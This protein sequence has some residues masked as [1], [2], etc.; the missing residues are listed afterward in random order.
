[1]GLVELTPGANM[2]YLTL[3]GSQWGRRAGLATVAG[4]TC[5]LTLYMLLAVAG[6]GEVVLR[7]S[8]LYT[9][10]RWAGVGYLVWLAV[11][12]WRGGSGTSPGNA[13]LPPQPGRLFARGLIAN[14]L[15]PKAVVFYVALLPG[16]TNPSRG[17]LAIQA[18]SLGVIHVTLSVAVHTT[19]V[20]AA[21]G[22][23]RAVGGSLR[24][25]SRPWIDRA[26]ALGLAA[27]AVWLAWE[28]FRSP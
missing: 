21:G 18:L 7:L 28:T 3:V 4:I 22:A 8:L 20:L 14:L 11:R 2:A 16:F 23:R 17:A 1:V 6:L 26:F 5:G 15:N 10:L 12:T 9:A 27:I 25:A 13:P 19:I 24:G